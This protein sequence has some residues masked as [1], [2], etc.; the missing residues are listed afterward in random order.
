MRFLKRFLFEEGGATAVEYAVML[1]MIMALCMASVGFFGQ[2]HAQ[3]WSDMSLTLSNAM[4]T[5][6]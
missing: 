3:S 1:A 4:N 5:G 6:S 2:E